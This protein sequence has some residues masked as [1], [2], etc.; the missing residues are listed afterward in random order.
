MIPGYHE[1]DV[2][3][4]TPNVHELDYDRPYLSNT[5]EAWRGLRDLADA[6]LAVGKARRND[7]LEMRGR[8]IGSAATEM[9][10]DARNGVGRSWVEKDGVVGLPIIA[11][12]RTFYWEHPYRAGLDRGLRREPRMV[13][14]LFRRHHLEGDRPA[15]LGHRRQARAYDA[16]RVQQPQTALSAF[17]S[18]KR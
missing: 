4:L 18:G 1:A 9:L 8:K 6:Y 12:D 15:H 13:G 5:G 11:G 16:R 10:A 14:A 2:N 17:W 7:R 3:F